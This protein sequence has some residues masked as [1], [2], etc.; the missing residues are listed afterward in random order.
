[1]KLATHHQAK[2]LGR[3]KTP[4]K[5]R[6]LSH[7]EIRQ[8]LDASSGDLKDMIIVAL[9]MGMRASEVLGL[10][11]DQVDLKNAVVKLKDAKNGDR[12]LVLL[13]PRVVAT[14]QQ[15]PA[16]LRELFPEWPLDKL[17]HTVQRVAKRAGL[18][19]VT[20]HTLRHTF[21]SHAVMAGVDLY[22]LAKILGHRDLAQVQRYAHLA[23]PICKPLRIWPL[24]RFLQ[25]TCHKICRTGS[26]L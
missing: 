16:P 22:T 1:M 25:G 3:L 7:E 18:Q 14:L 5:E 9:G 12:R 20:F 23:L 6:Y 15:R 21:A 26:G 13:P 24:R 19:G 8:L 2:G 17:M 4:I 11:R 10:D